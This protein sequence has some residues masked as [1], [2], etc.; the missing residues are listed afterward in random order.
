MLMSRL[1]IFRM[2]LTLRSGEAIDHTQPRWE[3]GDDLDD[4]MALGADIKTLEQKQLWARRA[5]TAVE[6]QR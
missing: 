4:G 2:L 3:R 1:L 6:L 5:Q